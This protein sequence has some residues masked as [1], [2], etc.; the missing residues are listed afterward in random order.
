MSA[1]TETR[2]SE[3]CG[4]RKQLDKSL[5]ILSLPVELLVYIMYFLPAARDKVKMR[6]VSRTLRVVSET[7]SLWSEFV[8]PLY[9]R[10]EE[11]SVMNV[12][13]ACGD[14][15][16]RLAFP[17]HVIPSTLIEILSHCK[18]VTQL[19]LPSG[20]KI[21]SEELRLA[22]QHMEHLESLEAQLS[23]DIKPLLKI[24]G[25]KELTVH[26]PEEYHSLCTPWV[27]EWMKKCCIPC[28]FNLITER[29]DFYEE[30][31]FLESLLQCNIAPLIGYTSYFK[32]YYHFELPLNLFPN[33]PDFQL[34]IDQTVILP[35]VKAS[36][37]GILNLKCD[38]LAL[39]DHVCNGKRVYKVDNTLPNFFG[40][41]NMVFNNLD[42]SISCATELYATLSL[43]ID[44]LEQLA[45]A[46]PKLQ[47]LCLQGSG[48]DAFTLQGLCTIAFHCPYLC[49]L[50]MPEVGFDVIGSHV[51]FWK[52]LSEMKLTHLYIEMCLLFSVNSDEPKLVHLFQKC[53][54]LQALQIVSWN[55]CDWCEECDINWSLL[56]HFPALKYC[57]FSVKHS[58]VVQDVIN[59]CKQLTI[60]SC[61]Y[62]FTECFLSSVC[63]ST[64]QQLSIIAGEDNTNIPDIFMETVSVH[65]GLVHVVFDVQ[66]VSIK[67]IASLVGNSP[68]L[69]TCIVGAE[70]FITDSEEP[71]LSLIKNLKDSLQQKFHSRKL[72]TVG[73]FTVVCGNDL[74]V[75]DRIPGT[76][77][78]PLWRY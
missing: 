78:F 73:R 3:N 49:G 34:E 66:S 60:L 27:E 75:R 47:R 71:V 70:Q 52:I 16:K 23:T 22:V 14:Y 77:L 36:K 7:P 31:S 67:A 6:Y 68:K 20:T 51:E 8:W 64:L 1:R 46:C 69:L 11:R 50:N 19:S 61:I 63:T 38:V 4:G 37:F 29:F 42:S 5:H 32:L 39:T 2:I 33:L 40:H 59:S 35:F 72:F 76:D 41:Q 9:D 57:R 30:I 74:E 24:G 18:N 55:S 10:R 28:N 44:I 25:L 45:F 62:N 21:D 43:G 13:K 58:A 15:T 26:V 48:G 12:L 53:S 54:S 56:S 65:G 17:D